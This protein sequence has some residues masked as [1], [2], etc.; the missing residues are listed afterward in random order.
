MPLDR[1]KA[2]EALLDIGVFD[3]GWNVGQPTVTEVLD[4]IEGCV[5]PRLAE[6]DVRLISEAEARLAC[7]RVLCDQY[8]AEHYGWDAIRAILDAPW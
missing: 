7:I 8:H 1:E 5:T 6:V 4:A 2:R 3:D